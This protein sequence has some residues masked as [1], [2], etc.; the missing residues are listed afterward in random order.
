MLNFSTDQW[1]IVL[2]VFVLGLLLGGFLFTGGGRKW[3]ARY[4]TEADRRADLERTHSAREKEWREQDSLR[5][6]AL[7]DRDR[8]VVADNRDEIVDRRDP[9]VDRRDSDSDGVPDDRDPVDD[10]KV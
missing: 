4:N 2:L 10:R 5:A 8:E 9:V 6:A 1:I 7:K 3:K